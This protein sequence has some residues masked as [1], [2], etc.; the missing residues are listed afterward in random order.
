[1]RQSSECRALSQQIGVNLTKEVRIRLTT[2]QI[3]THV[4]KY[5]STEFPSSIFFSYLNIG[6]HFP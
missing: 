3:S 6:T 1:L 5:K 4:D 2:T